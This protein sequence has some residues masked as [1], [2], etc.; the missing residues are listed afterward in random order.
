LAEVMNDHRMFF[1]YPGLL[2]S[3]TYTLYLFYKKIKLDYNLNQTHIII[4]SILFLSI[5]AFGTFQR[6]KVWDSDESLWLDVIEKSPKN[7]R[8]L[9]NYG[10]SQMRVG[11]YNDAETYFLKA[12]NYTPHYYILHINLGLLYNIKG[13]KTKAEKYLKKAISYGSNFY[14][15][16]FFYGDFLKNNKRFKES[17][18]ALEQSLTLAPKHLQTHLFLMDNYLELEQW[19]KLEQTALKT[20][21]I[22]PNNIDARKSL[23]AS[24]NKT[25]KLDIQE[26]LIDKSPSENSYLALSNAFFNKKK[27]LKCIDVAY[28]VL[29]LNPQNEIA[30]NIICCSYNELKN[31]DKAIEF[32]TKALELNPNYLLAKN[33]L[34]NALNKKNITTNK[35]NTIKSE[36]EYINESLALFTKQ[37]FIKAIDFC[38]EGLQHYPKSVI[39]YNNLCA[40]YN[41]L[42]QWKLGNEACKKGLMIDS[43]NQLLKNNFDWSLKHIN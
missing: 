13:D 37:D 23:I 5:Y 43:K 29:E 19:K 31:F 7:G 32:C 21:A 34:A 26:Q 40:T 15:P 27:Y 30:Y 18:N 33:N 8:G 10:L 12:L 42:K 35:I 24:K 11:K 17:I 36:T 20:L 28:K 2:L 38:K 22:A 16:Y 25:S 39:L 6:N 9:M 4:I 3:L 41:Q 1:P 14:Q